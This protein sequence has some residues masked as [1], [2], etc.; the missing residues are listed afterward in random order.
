MSSIAA[1]A[2]KSAQLFVRSDV[3]NEFDE[4]RVVGDQHPLE[5]VDLFVGPMPFGRTGE[6]LDALQDVAVPE[7]SKTTIWPCC[8]RRSQKRRL[9]T[10]GR[11]GDRVHLEATRVERPTQ[12]ANDADLARGVPTLNN[13]DSALGRPEIGLLNALKRFLKFLETALVVGELDH[14]ETLNFG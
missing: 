1:S 12:T 8:S 4:P 6:A 10:L 11:S 7:R 9:L 13:V 3:Q 14:W 5:V 2:A